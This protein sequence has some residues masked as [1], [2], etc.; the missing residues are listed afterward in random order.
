[1]RK[2]AFLANWYIGPLKGAGH[3][4]HP[5]SDNL[6]H[7]WHWIQETDQGWEC[8]PLVPGK[9]QHFQT[10]QQAIDHA[11]SHG[12]EIY[13]HPELNTKFAIVP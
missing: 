7:G 11:T 5:K 13:D 12:F 6:T 2:A 9:A 4:Q 10:P 8:V 3:R 1:M